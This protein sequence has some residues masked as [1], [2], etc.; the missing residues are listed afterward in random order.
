[1]SFTFE[2]LD[3]P[4]VVLARPTVRRD[5]RGWFMERYRA[6]AFAE[7]GIDAEF[8]QDNVVHSGPGVLRGM[9]F[10]LDPAAQG[11][12]VSVLRGRIFDV[13]VDL[14]A[15]SPTFGQ[16]VGC[17]LE[18]GDGA[19][20]WIPEGFAHGYAVL[21]DEAL[22]TYKVTQEFDPDLDRGFRWDDPEVG[23]DWPLTDPV[24]SERD[25]RLPELGALG[26]P[27]QKTGP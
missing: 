5:P 18:E 27:F 14:R 8:V 6:S 15:E 12:L 16:W 13:A 20:L 23:I 26:S 1:M 24:L 21:G 17:P 4:D 7:G 25:R 2:P 10:Q 19:A 9:H 3:L 11:K 22:V